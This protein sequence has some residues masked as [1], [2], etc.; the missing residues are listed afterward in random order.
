MDAFLKEAF[1]GE[2]GALAHAVAKYGD[3]AM[4]SE[5]LSIFLLTHPVVLDTV[6]EANET[7]CYRVEAEAGIQ[8][9]RYRFCWKGAQLVGVEDLGM[10]TDE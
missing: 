10:V 9:R 8:H 5:E 7:V 2:E 6:T 1:S 4:V 3:S